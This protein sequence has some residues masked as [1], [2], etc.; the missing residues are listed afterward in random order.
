[1]L[2]LI[3]L[4]A[5]LGDNTGYWFGSKVGPALWQRPD[6]RFFKKAYLERTRDFYEKHGIFAIVLAR[7][8]PIIRTF[9]P[10]V[11]G[12][13]GMNYRHFLSLNIVG[14]VLWGAGV[15]FAGYFL[16]EKIPFVD[17]YITLI[18]VAIVVA[19]L[20]PLF[21]HWLKARAHKEKM[22]A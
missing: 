22:N 14:G 6:S 19:S 9:A 21:T 12:I 3:T 8:I 2:F 4:A 18:I 13:T 11:A 7:F 17:K 20:V 15:T 16:G 5:I 1:M 10:I